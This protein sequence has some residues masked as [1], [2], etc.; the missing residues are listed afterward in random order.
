MEEGNLVT[1]RGNELMMWVGRW[2]GLKEVEALSGRRRSRGG[3]GFY[4]EE[5]EMMK[6]RRRGGG[7]LD[8]FF[9]ILIKR[10]EN[11]KLLRH[12]FLH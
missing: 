12:K 2:G 11:E 6:G 3:G 10:N 5:N 1:A 9:I 4:D 7:K 8:I